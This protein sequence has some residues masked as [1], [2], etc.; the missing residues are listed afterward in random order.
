MV[1]DL[2]EE[3]EGVRHGAGSECAEVAPEKPEASDSGSLESSLLNVALPG[4]ATGAGEGLS[5]TIA[6][7][8]GGELDAPTMLEFTHT[9]T[10][11]PRHQPL[12]TKKRQHER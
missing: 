6:A 10:H 7:P 3:K 11:T 12:P 4:E 5:S 8:A 9:C 2:G 1:L